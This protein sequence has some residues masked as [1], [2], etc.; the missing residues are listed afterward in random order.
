MIGG[1]L[2]YTFLSAKGYN[3]NKSLVNNNLMDEVKELLNSGKVIIPIDVVTENMIKDVEFL[4][5]TD[6]ILD[7]GPKTIKLFEENIDIDNYVLINGTVGKYEEDKYQNGTMEIFKYLS[8]NNIKTVVC[9]GDGGSASK[10]FGFKPYYLSTGGG[11]SLE[12]LE[13]KEMLPL[14]IM[15]E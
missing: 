9:G 4:E 7:I 5:E 15:E 12:F 10:K 3:V 13:D 14:K 2:S 1:G 11:A 6:N 8:D